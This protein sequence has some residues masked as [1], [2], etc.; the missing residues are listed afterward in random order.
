MR[1]WIFFVLLALVLILISFFYFTQKKILPSSQSNI[2]NTYYNDRFNFSIRYP[3]EWDTLQGSDN[4]DG[5]KLYEKQGNDILVYG[6]NIVDNS[7]KAELDADLPVVIEKKTTL[8]KN[9]LRFT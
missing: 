5:T 6:C 2:F 9:Y 8:S 7:D 3:K 4:G 1:K